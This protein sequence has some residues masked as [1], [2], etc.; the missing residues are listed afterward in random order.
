MA[1]EAEGDLAVVGLDGAGGVLEFLDGEAGVGVLRGPGTKP[2]AVG[3]QQMGQVEGVLGIVVGAADDEGLAEFLEADRVDGIE[4]DP[5]VLA[6]EADEVVGRLFEDDGHAVLGE[7]FTQVGGPGLKGG[8]IG[9]EDT[10]LLL[11]REQIQLVEI[12]LAIGTVHADDQVEGGSLGVHVESFRL[13]LWL[14]LTEGL[15]AALTRRRQYRTVPMESIWNGLW[16]Q[17][18]QVKARPGGRTMK[19]KVVKRP[20]VISPVPPGREIQRM[21]YY[22]DR[23]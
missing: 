7:A 17:S 10:G 23:S 19:L 12:D 15:H 16:S 2:L 11:L 22:V 6:Q 9:G 18:F 4:G 5:S 3:G 21:D 20:N 8:R 14:R 13:R 1:G